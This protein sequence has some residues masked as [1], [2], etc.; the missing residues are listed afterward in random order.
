MTWLVWRQHRYEILGMLI[1]ALTVFAALVYGADYAVRVR[2]ELGVDTCQP[3]PF[4][5]FQCAMLAGQA[6]DRIQAL[7]WLLLALLFLPAIVGSFIGGPLFARDLDRGTHRL[8]W[9]QAITRTR[10]ATTKLLALCG[11][12]AL[13]TALVALVGNR[14][15]TINGSAANAYSNFD[16]EGPALVSYVVFAIVIAA[17]VGTLSRRILTGMFVGLLVFGIFRLGVELGL[18]P[19]YEPPI[20]VLYSDAARCPQCAVTDGAWVVSVDYI[21]RTGSVVT[22]QRIRG[23]NNSFRPGPG[24]TDT[25]TYFAQNDAYQRVRFQPADRYWRFQWTEGFIFLALSGLFAFATLQLVTRR[26]A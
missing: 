17:F 20:T 9:T 13:T 26:D 10:W 24:R 25:V 23:L 14:A 11:V 3:T 16:L 22:P 4:T 19:N 12:A 6:A 21:D 7:R 2:R 18:R 1:G 5:N 8:I 15:A